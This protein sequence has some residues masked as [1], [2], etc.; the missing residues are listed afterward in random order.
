MR[1]KKLISKIKLPQKKRQIKKRV[2]NCGIE[3]DMKV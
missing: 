3:L 2:T 1:K